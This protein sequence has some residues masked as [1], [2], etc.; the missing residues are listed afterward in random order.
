MYFLLATVRSLEPS[1]QSH[2][3]FAGVAASAANGEVI[4]LPERSVVIEVLYSCSG[5]GPRMRGLLHRN[6]AIYA[7]F[8]SGSNLSLILVGNTVGVGHGLRRPVCTTF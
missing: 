4:F 2:G 1:G 5:G 6:M 7:S 8:V 3:S